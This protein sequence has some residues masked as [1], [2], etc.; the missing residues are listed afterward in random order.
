MLVHLHGF[1]QEP[2]IAWK[3]WLNP[4]WRTCMFVRHPCSQ[5]Y[6]FNGQCICL[7]CLLSLECSLNFGVTGPKAGDKYS[8]NRLSTFFSVYIWSLKKP[9][10]SNISVI[11]EIMSLF[12]FFLVWLLEKGKLVLADFLSSDNHLDFD[13][14]LDWEVKGVCHWAQAEIYSHELSSLCAR[15]R[16]E[17]VPSMFWE[18]TQPL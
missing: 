5:Y 2:C 3:S 13:N 8:C 9:T 15:V 4:C 12:K 6:R 14:H 7:H 11:L 17:K 18:G 16:L 10:K 1:Y